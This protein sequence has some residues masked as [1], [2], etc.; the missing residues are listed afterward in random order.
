MEEMHARMKA[1]WHKYKAP[2]RNEKKKKKKNSMRRGDRRIDPTTRQRPRSR[3]WR[4][5]EDQ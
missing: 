4:G 5:E 3:E 1:L 2:P